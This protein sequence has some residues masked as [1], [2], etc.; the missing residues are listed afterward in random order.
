MMR[1]DPE[2]YEG[3]VRV[4]AGCIP[5]RRRHDAVHV[6]LVSSSK[7]AALTPSALHS[8]LQD[9]SVFVLPKGGVNAGEPIAQVRA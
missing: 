9:R 2:Q 5:Y 8:H 4:V 6:L 7:V 3:A 1:H